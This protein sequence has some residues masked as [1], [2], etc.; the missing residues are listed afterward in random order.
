MMPG[1]LSGARPATP[2]IYLADKVRALLEEKINAKYEKFKAI[3]YKSQ[4]VAG[5]N[6]FIKMDVGGGCF[7]HIK[8]FRGLSGEDNLELSDYQTNKTKNDELSYF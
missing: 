7:L 5:Q 2:E 8:V 6:Y 3:E 1:G 4:V